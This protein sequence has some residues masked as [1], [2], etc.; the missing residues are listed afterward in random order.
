MTELQMI[1]ISNKKPTDVVADFNK[2]QGKKNCR[3]VQIIV[4]GGTPYLV[5]EETKSV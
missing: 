2:N 3:I 5:I 4:L 1:D